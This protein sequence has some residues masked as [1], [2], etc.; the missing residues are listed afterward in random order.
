MRR[1]FGEYVTDTYT[2]S[3]VYINSPLLAFTE[4]DKNNLELNIINR[5]HI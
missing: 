4:K 2:N 3:L 1:S 5:L